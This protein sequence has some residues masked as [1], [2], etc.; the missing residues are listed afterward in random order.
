MYDVVIRFVCVFLRRLSH[1]ELVC[2][3][4]TITLL[5]TYLLLQPDLF[6]ERVD[7]LDLKRLA[8]VRSEDLPMNG[9]F[10]R[11]V[12]LEEGQLYALVVYDDAE[13]GI[14]NGQG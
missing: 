9:V 11:T 3:K 14:E 8:V 6:L 7:G 13:D 12:V 1:D 10:T 4:L 5:S 2:K